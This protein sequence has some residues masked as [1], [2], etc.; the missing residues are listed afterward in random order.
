VQIKPDA[1]PMRYF[2]RPTL[3]SDYI[4]G[5]RDNSGLPTISMVPA[6]RHFHT[7]RADL[8]G[9]KISK[10]RCIDTLL[11]HC[12]APQIERAPASDQAEEISTIN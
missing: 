2:I 7:T 6:N 12:K 8:A 9:D 4:G 11:T 3:E 10:L 1:K 5:R